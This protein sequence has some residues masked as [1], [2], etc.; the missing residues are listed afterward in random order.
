M[1]FRL[2]EFRATLNSV[3]GVAK[4]SRFAVYITSPAF[5]SG[6]A[7]TYDDYGENDLVTGLNANMNI[8]DARILS[9]LCDSTVLPGKSLQVQE[10]RPQGFGKVSKMPYDIAHDPLTMSFMLDN[11]HRV[12]NFMQYWFQEI[13]NTGSDFEG[14]S[15]TFKNR[16]AY[17]LNYK[18][19]YATTMLIH[20]FSSYDEN[21]FIQYEFHDVY[22][23]QLGG[24]QLGWDQT[25]QFARLP[26]EFSYSS[27]STFRGSL[28]ML[29][30]YATRGVD[31]YQ[32]AGYSKN[33]L[34]ALTDSS[35][36]IQNLIESFT[37]L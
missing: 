32:R 10:Y 13:M 4:P 18:K 34:S 5:I 9:L 21:S 26:V 22:P 17:E 20:F 27:Y 19:S 6:V 12:M 30:T 7:S 23:M 1:A 36:G 3:G 25:D 2:D 28:S 33:L 35:Y 16:T 29:G 8:A 15:S 31:F 14:N 24:V 11:N 37:N